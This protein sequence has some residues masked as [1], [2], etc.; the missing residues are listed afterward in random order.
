MCKAAVVMIF[1]VVAAFALSIYFYP[2]MPEPMATHWN[3]KGEVNGYM[4]R[5]W[6]LFLMPLI[7][8]G[9]LGLFAVIPKIDPLRGNYGKFMPF[10]KGF[11][12]LILAFLLYIHIVSIAANLGFSMNMTY[13]VI[14]PL[15]ALFLFIGFMLPKAKRNWFVGIRTPWTLSS[16]KVWDKTHS[17]GGKLFL[18]Y[19]L[20]IL[21]LLPF[22]GLIVE[23]FFWLIVGP[24]LAM[25][26][27]L[28]I[29]SYWEY[30]K[31]EKKR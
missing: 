10:Y 25:T 20:F 23:H 21:A 4:P 5:F 29:Y 30:Y 11:V 12:L 26:A 27:S 2:Q 31:G 9:L 22:Y 3:E 8:L 13:L 7:A 17:I 1:L 24:I 15:A 18:L 14:P 28:F 6:G 19:G 16:D